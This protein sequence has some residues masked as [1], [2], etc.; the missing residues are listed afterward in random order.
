MNVEEVVSL[1]RGHYVQG[2]RESIA[3]LK[4][5]EGTSAAELLVEVGE[6]RHPRPYSLYRLDFISGGND[7]PKITEFNR[8]SFLE[9]IPF[10]FSIGRLSCTL[11]PFHWNGVEIKATGLP[12][13]WSQ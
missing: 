8:D 3:R 10:N 4:E 9:F 2:L 11:H 12:S 1:A 5:V 7:A 13:D 6:G